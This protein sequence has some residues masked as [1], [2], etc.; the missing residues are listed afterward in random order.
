MRGYHEF[1][2]RRVL[3]R[4]SLELAFDGRRRDGG[5]Y[6]KVSASPA[7]IDDIRIVRIVKNAKE[8]AFAQ[9]FAVATEKRPC[10]CTHTGRRSGFV[11]AGYRLHGTPY[12]IKCLVPGQAKSA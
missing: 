12:K 5:T 10:S 3:L 4:R 6:F 7:Q 1:R 2:W 11:T 9:T 8:I